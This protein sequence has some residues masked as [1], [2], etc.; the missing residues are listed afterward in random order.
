MGEIHWYD[1]EYDDD[2]WED[3]DPTKRTDWLHSGG[4][5]FASDEKR[6]KNELKKAI[7]KT[8]AFKDTQLDWD[9][10]LPGYDPEND[11]VDNPLVG[12]GEEHLWFDD[13]LPTTSVAVPLEISIK[14]VEEWME[15][16][17]VSP[18]R[19]KRWRKAQGLDGKA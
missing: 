7:E 15:K 3:D 4:Y 12:E 1:I 6:G 10:E 5:D 18:E 16:Y 2:E 19:R 13:V 11:W 9:K 8:W 17:N 14:R